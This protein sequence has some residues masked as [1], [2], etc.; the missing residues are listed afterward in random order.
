[1]DPL[2]GAGW[3][4]DPE[5]AAG[6]RWW[7][8]HQWG[9]RTPGGTAPTVARGPHGV[10]PR[11]KG[12]WKVHDLHVFPDRIALAPV[13]GPDPETLGALL[14]FLVLCGLLGAIIGNLIGRSI[15]KSATTTRL[16]RTATSA[17][18]ALAAYEGAE[19][20]PKESIAALV[21]QHHGSGGRIRMH[22]T[23]G[24]TRKFSWSRAHVKDVD[25]ERLLLDVA[26]GRSEV[27][28]MST[29][30]K[31]V[32]LLAIALLVLLG[33]GI[34]G[35]IIAAAVAPDDE[36]STS[37]LPAA[38]AE[39]LSRACAEWSVLA[40]SDEPTVEEIQATITRVRPDLE[41]AAAADPSFRQAADSIGFL[42]SYFAAPTVE[43]QP[44]VESAAGD[45]DAACARS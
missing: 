34:V 33:L 5:G 32:R 43:Q 1:M 44:Q 22:L 23:D 4:P 6:L 12:N 35:G 26:P 41:Q 17:P 20:L 10:V 28:P 30:S 29:L 21:A 36:R 40:G 38:V 7:D 19:V 13:K 11:L 31:V 27:K 45:V 2:S 3:Y 16:A 9:D 37:G 14:G 8:G 15:A 25:I 18:E 24:T 39:P 42:D